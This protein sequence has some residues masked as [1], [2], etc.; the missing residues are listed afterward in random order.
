[1]DLHPL[2]QEIDDIDRRL[3]ELLAARKACVENVAEIKARE[4]LS[5]RQPARFQEVLARCRKSAEEQGFDPDVAEV[6]WQTLHEYFVRLE[7]ARLKRYAR[8]VNTR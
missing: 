3:I 7:E 6:I 5:A 8:R 2:R 1:M 4:G